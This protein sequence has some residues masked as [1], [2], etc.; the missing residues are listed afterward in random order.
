[1]TP[2]RDVSRQKATKE[3]TATTA[4]PVYFCGG[5][6]YTTSK[7]HATRLKMY[8]LRILICIHVNWSR[9]TLLCR[10]QDNK[11]GHEMISVDPSSCALYNP[12][13]SDALVYSCT[14]CTTP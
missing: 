12:P 6:I 7:S 13:R 10:S 5:Y 1:M 11:D 3:E 8:H 4:E 2:Q 14:M 9:F